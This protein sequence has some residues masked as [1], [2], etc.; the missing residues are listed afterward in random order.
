MK[1]IAI[2]LPI[3][4]LCIQ[5]LSISLFA[6]PTK[7][8]MSLTS[9]PFGKT[10]AGEPVTLYTLKNTSGMEVQIMNYGGIITKILCPDKNNQMEDVVLGYET[11]QE[12]EKG[13]PYFGAIIGRYG[14]RIAKGKFSLDSKNY[15]LY[16]QNM[17]NHL[18][19]GKV[20]FDK[21]VW[22]V[23]AAEGDDK[24]SKL[25]LS[26]LSKDGEEGYPG[27][28]Q[29]QVTYT[30]SPANELGIE[31]KAT[32]DKATVLNLSNHT[33]FNLSGNTKRDITGHQV[34]LNANKLVAVDETLIPTGELLDVKGGAFDFLQPHLISERVDADDIQIK[35]GG[36]Y[37]HCVVFDKAPGV[38]AKV[39]KVTDPVSGRSVELSTSEPATQFYTGNFL[40]GTYSGKYGVNYTKRMGFCL[41]TEHFPDSPNHPSFP[42]TV[43]RPGQ[44]YASK[45]VYQFTHK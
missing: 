19:G 11:L 7:G 12:Y 1:K 22:K 32:T 37:D 27:N 3:A 40:N 36:G 16:T 29:V 9:K 6:K 41:E 17:G 42:S 33:Y 5:I 14:N 38:F 30:L 21:V 24:G 26:Y 25:V 20:G 4:F 18:H 2:W 43:L 10:Q 8:P 23:L 35:R 15:E 34:Q 31:Y 44:T 28:L 13:S 39:G 45:T